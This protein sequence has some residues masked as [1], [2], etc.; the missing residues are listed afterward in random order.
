MKRRDLLAPILIALPGF[1]AAGAAWL[2]ADAARRGDR[3][4]YKQ[5]GE[6]LG[7]LAE[8]IEALEGQCGG[9]K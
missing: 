1:L 7:S 2:Q 3:E 9:K 6:S 8:R 5:A 4:T